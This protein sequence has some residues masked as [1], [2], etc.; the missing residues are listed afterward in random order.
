MTSHLA[1]FRD[2]R[3]FVLRI[4]TTSNGLYRDADKYFRFKNCRAKS[5]LPRQCP[6]LTSSLASSLTLLDSHLSTHCLR[7][8]SPLS[9]I[10]ALSS[11]G[12]MILADDKTA[13]LSP[14][15][16]SARNSLVSASDDSY[17]SFGSDSKY[18]S[19]VLKGFPHVSYLTS[20]ILHTTNSI[21][22]TT[23]TI[24]TTLAPP[25]TSK[26]TVLP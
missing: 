12:S 21:P 7:L 4:F 13:P 9:P 11:R 16:T 23:K 2:I 19:T 26:Q 20:T 15:F 17:I 25:S 6:N 5:S 24:S 10:T 22:Q 3:S 18:P 14:R 8:S 1:T